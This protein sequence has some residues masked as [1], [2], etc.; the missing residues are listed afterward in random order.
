MRCTYEITGPWYDYRQTSHL[1]GGE[2]PQQLVSQPWEKS[3]EG[4]NAKEKVLSGEGYTMTFTWVFYMNRQICLDAFEI[5][6][7]TPPTPHINIL[8][9]RL[10]FTSIQVRFISMRHAFMF[11]GYLS[12][13]LRLC[14]HPKGDRCLKGTK[15]NATVGKRILAKRIRCFTVRTSKGLVRCKDFS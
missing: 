1:E 6:D 11:C 14:R 8:T 4:K 2:R 3:G 10:W 9:V 13:V 5:L 7:P 15:C 12:E